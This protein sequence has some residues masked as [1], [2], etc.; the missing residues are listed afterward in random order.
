MD[1]FESFAENFIKITTNDKK[2]VP[3]IMNDEQKEFDKGAGRF[4]IILKARQLGFTTYSRCKM[5][6]SAIRHPNTA[7]IIVSHNSELSK[8]IFKDLKFSYKN[9]PHKEFAEYG[10]FPKVVKDNR[11]EFELSNGSRIIIATASGGDSISGYT[12]EMI[13]FSEFAKFKEGDENQQELLATANPALAKNS[14]AKI[15]IEST[16]MGHNY[17]YELFMK[18]WKNKNSGSVWKPFFYSWLSKGY[19][20]QFKYAYDEAEQWYKR[21]NRG[22]RLSMD[23]LTEDEI[24]LQNKPFNASLRHLMYRR[25]QINAISEEKFKREFPST[26]LEAFST[27][28]V[29]M[30]DAGKIMEALENKH[31]KISNLEVL[32]SD[33][34]NSLRRYVG[35]SLNIYNMPSKLV[36]NDQGKYRRMKYFAGIDSALGRGADNSTITILDV[37]GEEAATFADNKIPVHKFSEIIVDLCRWYNYALI[38]IENNG[39]GTPIVEKVRQELKYM[40]MIKFKAYGKGG[41]SKTRIGFYMD[42]DS[43]H[44]LILQFKEHFER[45]LILIKNEETLNEMSIFMNIEGKMGNKKRCK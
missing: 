14:D 1:D 4:N 20:K 24:I 16:A 6:Y 37:N 19:L 40:N 38:A 21:S 30:F 26:P 23:E 12:F 43:K 8:K 39:I 25:Y 35:K 36:K 17:F 27:S 41:K 18:A 15:I 33:I 44:T 34:P 3:F 2:V 32:T 9:L 7:Y 45:D 31:E 10:I 5:L 22:K 28:S 42:R 29:A 11:G 13:H